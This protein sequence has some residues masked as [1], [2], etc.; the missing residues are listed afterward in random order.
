L[1]LHLRD[2]GEKTQTIRNSASVSQFTKAER[3]FKR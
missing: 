2:I 1:P 3:R